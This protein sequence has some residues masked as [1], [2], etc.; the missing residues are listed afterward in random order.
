MKEAVVV[1]A[2]RTP[3]GRM[4]GQLCMLE[5]EQLLAPLIQGLVHE[6]RLPPEWIDD[7]IIGNVVGP[8][9]NIARKSVLQ[10]GLPET[11][12]G[13]TVDR[14]CGS[15]LEAIIMAARLIQS[16]AGEIF[17]AGGV[18]STS[19]APWRML[20]P[21]TVSG[22]P[23]M[24][25]RAA[26]T[27]AGFGD[28]DMG[29]AAEY[30]AE[31]Y[32]ISREL[33]D[34][35]ALESHMKALEAQ[36]TGRFAAELM[37]IA[38]DGFMVT[39][40]EC[41]RTDTSLLKL[42]RLKPAFVEGGTVT[43]GNACPLNDGAAL[44]LMMSRDICDRL[45]LTPVLRFVDSQASG[46]DPHYP[47]MGPVPAVRRLLQRQR[48]HINELDIVEFNEAFASQVLASLQELQLSPDKVNLGGGALALG[49]PYGASGA[50][51][52]TRLYAEMLYRPYRRGLATLGIG[53]GMGLAVLVEGIQRN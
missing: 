24:Y 48:L 35:Y 9:G 28:P 38:V 53:G 23:R 39:D 52:M 50:I 15:G 45:N 42:S 27:P 1:L 6:A 29:L 47:G 14:Q 30:T 26:F 43:A 18:E 40:D 49:H 46:V 13:V 5:P 44:V 16:G 17:L 41:P 51:L 32:G 37:P 8:G 22:T 31:K 21:E 25:T 3:V 11:V 12:P 33:Q 20:R 36:R 10:A 7:V 2:K 34:R 19:R 4:G